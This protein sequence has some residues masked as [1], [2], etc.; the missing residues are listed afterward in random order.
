MNCDKAM[1]PSIAFSFPKRESTFTDFA[2]PRTMN[3][4]KHGA[5]KGSE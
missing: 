2:G 4:L 5:E 3:S 1:P